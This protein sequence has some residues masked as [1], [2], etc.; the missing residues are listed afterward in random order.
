V[1]EGARYLVVSLD[2]SAPWDE[3]SF[4][5]LAE[6]CA[7]V[8]RR[9]VEWARGT[10]SARLSTASRTGLWINQEGQTKLSTTRQFDARLVDGGDASRIPVV[11]QRSECRPA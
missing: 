11:E 5:I 1:A 6:S 2:Y 9:Y 10:R 4:A 8:A 7:K 3:E